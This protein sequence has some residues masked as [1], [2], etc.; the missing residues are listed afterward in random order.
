MATTSGIGASISA[1]LLACALVSCARTEQAAQRV[2]AQRERE[3]PPDVRDRHDYHAWVIDLCVDDQADTTLDGGE[4]KAERG[5]M[6]VDCGPN[7]SDEA[8]RYMIHTWPPDSRLYLAKNL[9]KAIRDARAENRRLDAARV[10]PGPEEY[11]PSPRPGAC[12]SHGLQ[13]IRRWA[14]RQSSIRADF[15]GDGRDDRLVIY[16]TGPESYGGDEVRLRAEL[17]NGITTDHVADEWHTE[18][19]AEILGTSDVDNDGRAEAWVGLETNKDFNLGLLM[20][21]SCDAREVTVERESD[22][23]YKDRLDTSSEYGPPPNSTGNVECV[24]IDGDGRT[25][26]VETRHQEKW[27]KPQTDP[28]DEPPS[29]AWWKYTAFRLDGSRLRIVADDNGKELSESPNALSW[30]D[31]WSDDCLEKERQSARFS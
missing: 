26:I 17:A 23:Y 10:T 8:I 18:W 12:A 29:E 2:T 16:S 21:D 30:D 15:D 20:F 25:E 9:D 13:D 7:A 28:S 11:Y 22:S 24:D 14:D 31:D 1:L 5:R 6:G 19:G 4:L 3:I 27:D